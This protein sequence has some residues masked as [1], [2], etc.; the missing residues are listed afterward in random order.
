MQQQ[1]QGG[2]FPCTLRGTTCPGRN[3]QSRNSVLLKTLRLFR[4]SEA[5]KMGKG[6]SKVMGDET[7]ACCTQHFVTF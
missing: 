2:N 1:G 3:V 4:N 5:A 6:D 7:G